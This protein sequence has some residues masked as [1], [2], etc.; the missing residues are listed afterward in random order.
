MTNCVPHTHNS[1]DRAATPI[2]NL[3]STI[4][5]NTRLASSPF[6]APYTLEQPHI[7]DTSTST[8]ANT[9]SETHAQLTPEQWNHGGYEGDP[10]PPAPNDWPF[11]DSPSS[12]TAIDYGGAGSYLP[13]GDPDSEY[14][15]ALYYGLAAQFTHSPSADYYMPHTHEATNLGTG[16]EP[17][18]NFACTPILPAGIK[19]DCILPGLSLSEFSLDF[20]TQITADSQIDTPVPWALHFDHWPLLV[21]HTSAE[22]AA[23]S[24]EPTNISK[25]SRK[26]KSTK[27]A[28]KYCELCPL[29]EERLACL[30][31]K[32]DPELHVN[33]LSKNFDS[34]GH[35]RQHLDQ[36]HK[37]GRHHCTSCW[38]T[39]ETAEALTIHGHCTPTGGKPVDKLPGFPKTRIPLDNKWYWCW[40]QLFGEAAALPACPFYHPWN[41]AAAHIH[42]QSPELSRSK[43]M[44]WSC[45]SQNASLSSPDREHTPLSTPPGE[46]LVD[47]ENHPDIRESGPFVL[48]LEYLYTA[49]S[50][51][52]T[53]IS[54]TT[55]SWDFCLD[56]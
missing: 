10:I 23:S 55:R 54:A 36:N 20:P 38:R 37:L 40:R 46:H 5:S 26:G 56:I 47:D 48:P 14:A 43:N 9:Y 4:S 28:S 2:D 50:D 29:G 25:S 7:I 35:L 31:Y 33:C 27:S 44:G 49:G 34:I 53:D 21:D 18:G 17:T 13:S 12:T 16:V 45:S 24:A 42:A 3:G 11:Y 30:F 15:D 51:L 39:F 22:P 8:S 41:D 32:Y 1:A 6:L 19:A 52:S